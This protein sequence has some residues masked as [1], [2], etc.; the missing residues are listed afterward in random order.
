MSRGCVI[1]CV[2]HPTST[3][4]HGCSASYVYPV[5]VVYVTTETWQ[6]GDT[7]NMTTSESM[8]CVAAT[9]RHPCLIL[10]LLPSVHQHPLDHEQLMLSGYGGLD[11]DPPSVDAVGHYYQHATAHPAQNTCSGVCVLLSVR[12]ITPCSYSEDLFSVITQDCIHGSDPA[13]SEFAAFG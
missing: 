12:S 9:S 13:S 7:W 10:L 11:P 3:G 1:L 5:A 8:G 6:L 4:M 2:V